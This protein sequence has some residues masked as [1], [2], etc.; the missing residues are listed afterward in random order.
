MDRKEYQVQYRAEHREEFREY[1]KTYRK[2]AIES[3][4]IIRGWVEQ[5][6]SD[7]PCLDCGGVFPF[8]AMD[9]DHRPKEEKCFNIS[10]RGDLKATPERIAKWEKEI[11]KCDLVCANCHRVRTQDRYK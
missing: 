1:Q 3:G 10:T 4:S 5:K 11:A 7:V 9:F 2:R 6:H 8:I